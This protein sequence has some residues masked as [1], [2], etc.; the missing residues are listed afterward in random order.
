MRDDLISEGPGWTPGLFQF[1][2]MEDRKMTSKLYLPFN[3][4]PLAAKLAFGLAGVI[5]WVV[6]DRPTTA[7]EFYGALVVAAILSAIGGI[8]WWHHR[9]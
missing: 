3:R 4:I 9:H 5:G 6:S 2:V 7:H 1:P 8:I